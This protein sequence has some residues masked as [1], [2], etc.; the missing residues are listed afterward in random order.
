MWAVLH[1]VG[2]SLFQPFLEFVLVFGFAPTDG[3]LAASVFAGSFFS[4]SSNPSFWKMVGNF[5]AFGRL[6]IFFSSFPEPLLV[7]R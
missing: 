1:R 6:I 7:C 4:S 5:L 3:G 2:S